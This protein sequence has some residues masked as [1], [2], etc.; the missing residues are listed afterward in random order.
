MKNRNGVI[1]RPHKEVIKSSVVRPSFKILYTPSTRSFTTALVTT[2][3]PFSSRKSRTSPGRM[4]M[5][6]RRGL[7]IVT[8]PF[9]ETVAF[10][11]VKYESDMKIKQQ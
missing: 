9:F 2:N 7:G 3:R 5:R 6:S 10:T 11:L 8:C 1:T 4:F